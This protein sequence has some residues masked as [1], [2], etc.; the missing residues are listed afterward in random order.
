MV[1]RGILDGGHHTDC[2]G[3]EG[4]FVSVYL[5]LRVV[6]GC[7]SL[8]RLRCDFGTGLADPG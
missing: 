5:G 4:A 8:I 6:C 1:Q 2:M 3:R 7:L